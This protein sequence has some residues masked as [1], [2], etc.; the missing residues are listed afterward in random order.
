MAVTISVDEQRRRAVATVPPG[1]RLAEFVVAIVDEIE[2][3][4]D[5]SG[6]DWLI[7]DQG[8]MDDVNVEG[9][10]QVAAAYNR[11]RPETAPLRHTVVVTTDRFFGPWAKVMDLYFVQRLHH[12]APT[13]AVAHQLL[14][15]MSAD[16][17]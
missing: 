10:T 9:M 17:D 15:R 2:R 4:P 7:D 11:H 12:S 13:L 6:W 14:D 5:L 1:T 8:P 16:P 3:R